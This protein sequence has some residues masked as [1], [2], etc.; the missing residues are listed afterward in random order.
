[1][2]AGRKGVLFAIEDACNLWKGAGS[3]SDRKGLK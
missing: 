2:Y 1:M 3:L